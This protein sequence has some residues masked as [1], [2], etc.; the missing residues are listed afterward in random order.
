MEI[1]P[2]YISTTQEI[3]EALKWIKTNHVSNITGFLSKLNIKV[4]VT[5]PRGKNLLLDYTFKS[6][7]FYFEFR[8]GLKNLLYRL[9]S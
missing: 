4:N 6:K 5:T 9:W 2:E 1:R 3:R 8:R 7:Y